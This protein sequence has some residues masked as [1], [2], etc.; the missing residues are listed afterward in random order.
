MKKI[1]SL[2]L[3][4]LML[5]CWPA[6]SQALELRGYDSELGYEYV[7]LGRCPQ[8][9]D[10]GERDILWRVLDV[11]GDEAYLLSEYILF[12]TA[13]MRTTRNMRPSAA[14]GTGQSCISCCTGRSWT[15]GSPRKNWSTWCP[16]KS[17]GI[18]SWPPER[19]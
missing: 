19:I 5:A 18:S 14:S 16:A 12:N 2:L 7:A 15:S 8:D 3:S 11:S 9:E 10:G 13:Y 6:L 1:L 4:V 17:W